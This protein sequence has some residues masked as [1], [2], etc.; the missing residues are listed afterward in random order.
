MSI[1]QVERLPRTKYTT[2]LYQCCCPHISVGLQRG[3]YPAR[4]EG[5]FSTTSHVNRPLLPNGVCTTCSYLKSR[6][7]QGH[8][9]RS[10]FSAKEFLA[11]I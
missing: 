7:T 1:V 2:E 9:C 8:V 4:T 3:S 10:V 5:G 11:E 6:S